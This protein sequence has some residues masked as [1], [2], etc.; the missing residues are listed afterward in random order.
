MLLYMARINLLLST[1]SVDSKS[2]E[3]ET[4]QNVRRRSTS[5]VQI[6][7]IVKW[8]VNVENH[9]TSRCDVFCPS[10]S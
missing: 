1:S 4:V 8:H 10:Q 5:Q 7:Y 3:E 6:T 9:V 2:H